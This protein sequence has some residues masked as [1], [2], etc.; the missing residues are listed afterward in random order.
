MVISFTVHP[1]A[2]V[3]PTPPSHRVSRAVRSGRVPTGNGEWLAW[4]IGIQALLLALAI[5]GIVS[6]PSR[7]RAATWEAHTPPGD[8]PVM[9]MAAANRLPG[10]V[11]PG[12]T[13]A[14]ATE[15]PAPPMPEILESAIAPA[16]PARLAMDAILEALPMPDEHPSANPAK[17]GNPAPRPAARPAPATSA[18]TSR[19]ASGGGTGAGPVAGAGE[20]VPQVFQSAGSGRFP[21]PPYPPD[22]KRRGH[23]G[24]VTVDVDVDATGRPGLPRIESSS[25]YPALDR[26]AVSWINRRWRWPA[27]PARVFRIPIVFKLQ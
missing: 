26:A 20:V 23:E 6:R 3:P 14:H 2:T 27:G 1:A 12:A 13:P 8:V 17:V 22:A 21:L 5:T 10:E 24:K 7:D 15:V 18:R 9:E 25:G 11:L 16:A 4:C 19:Q